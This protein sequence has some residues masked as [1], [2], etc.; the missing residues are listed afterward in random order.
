MAEFWIRDRAVRTWEFGALFRRGL[1]SGMHASVSGCCLD[2]YSTL[3][4]PG[5]V[6]SRVRNAWLDS[7]Y[8]FCIS[9]WVWLD[10]G[11]MLC[12]LGIAV[13]STKIGSYGR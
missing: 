5:D 12:S 10:S 4:P 3:D 6:F 8:M 13:R 9:V 11:Y 7:G 2:E 1:E